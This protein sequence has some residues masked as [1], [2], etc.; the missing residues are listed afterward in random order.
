MSSKLQ[1]FILA[2]VVLAG[3]LG[4]V[5]WKQNVGG[6]SDSLTHVTKEQME[7]LV[8][9]LNP[10]QQRQ[11]AQSP[12]QKVELAKNL[13]EF[14]AIANQARK[15]GFANKPEVK[16]ELKYM[17]KAIL[18]LSYDKEKNKDKPMPPLSMITEDQITEFWGED[19]NKKDEKDIDKKE[20]EEK[21]DAEKPE[22]DEDKDNPDK[23]KVDPSLDKSSEATD[24][25]AGD[26][27]KDEATDK[28]KPKDEK[29]EEKKPDAA[30]EESKGFLDSIGLGGW[31]S[32]GEAKRH[33]AEFQEFLKAQKKLEAGR[34]QRPPGQEMSPEQLKQMRDS[35]ARF[36]IY[37]KE[38]KAKLG[39]YDA[40]VRA[41]QNEEIAKL[42]TSA[43]NYE[44]KK[45]EIDDKAKE[46][47]KSWKEFPHKVEFQTKLQ[48]S[49]LLAQLYAREKLVPQL[50]VSEEDVAKYIEEH[51]DLTKESKGKADEA[52]KRAKAGEDFAKLAKELSDDPGSKEKG[53][54]YE[55]VP[56]GQMIPAFEKAA[57]A[58]EPGQIA[59]ELVKTKFGYHIIKLEKKGDSEESEEEE[60]DGK[61]IETY[62]A[63][64]I[65][66]STTVRDE[67]SPNPMQQEVPLDTFITNKLKTEK[68]EEILAKI[69]KD[70]PIEVA[71]D[72]EVTPP[73]AP[74][75][76]QLPPGMQLPQQG[77]PQQQAPP[78]PPAAKKQADEKK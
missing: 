22:A 7:M 6:H 28:D 54:L 19:P 70:N 61:K 39:T 69:L 9:D 76:P 58:L 65:L 33:E 18:A 14:L 40:D 24:S 35:Y 5:Y 52:L 44:A 53:G 45:K 59:P 32:K 63:R 42:N 37:A 25:K 62:D 60:K 15:E 36:S 57:L 72:F 30:K 74:Q 8:K 4:L 49:Q 77:P 51:P 34:G 12:E 55:K 2:A 13:K 31:I 67:K 41:K 47:L 73:P 16:Q 50:E 27:A 56:M 26:D 3:G 43:K 17:E 10:M 11:L 68:Q 38:A 66:I 21:P 29:A 46:E 1:I 23:K 75:Q 20:G 71:T 48:Q 78:P 64:H